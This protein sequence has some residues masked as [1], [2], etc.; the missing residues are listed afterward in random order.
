MQD[1]FVYELQQDP[2]KNK[3]VDLFGFILGAK[4]IFSE[5]FRKQVQKLHDIAI[6]GNQDISKKNF[7]DVFKLLDRQRLSLLKRNKDYNIEEKQIAYELYRHGVEIKLLE[8]AK[9]HKQIKE[10]RELLGSE[11]VQRLLLAMSDELIQKGQIDSIAQTLLE[12]KNAY[13]QLLRSSLTKLDTE[14]VL[15]PGYMQAKEMIEKTYPFAFHASEVSFTQEKNKPLIVFSGINED[16]LV[17]ATATAKQSPHTD[18]ILL[19]DEETLADKVSDN[20]LDVRDGA[21]FRDGK[22]EWVEITETL[23]PS[24]MYAGAERKPK[25]VDV[26]V[27][28]IPSMDEYT[29]NK[30]VTNAIMQSNGICVPKFISLKSPQNNSSTLLKKLEEKG[31]HSSYSPTTEFAVKNL[32]EEKLQTCRRIAIKPTDGQCG[33]SV[34]FFD[35]TNSEKAAKYAFT[36]LQE[37]RNVI[38]EEFIQSAKLV[39][40]GKPMDWNVRVFITK[41]EDGD[42]FATDMIGRYDDQGKPVNLSLTAKAITKE[43]LLKH[44]NLSGVDASLFLSSIYSV[45]VKSVKALV[46]TITDYEKIDESLS[47]DMMG[48]DIIVTIVDGKLIPVFLEANDHLSG[49]MWDLE[50]KQDNEN[51]GLAMI[52]IAKQINRRTKANF[53]K[54]KMAA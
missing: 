2:D 36:L 7:E 29:E 16:I 31:V 5:N 34:E 32:I 50:M 47:Q 40:D 20:C 26:P 11:E 27:A 6:A 18:V 35:I 41:D 4:N 53:D 54:K 42:Y 44:L 28:S 25:L 14:K 30:E 39:I 43:E 49:G 38:I 37:G 15:S 13:T 51:K 33:E 24:Y 9:S 22:W 19:F 46:S 48:I 45:G 17:L 23:S 3:L 52:P 1:T 10:L 12:T 8:I 21:H